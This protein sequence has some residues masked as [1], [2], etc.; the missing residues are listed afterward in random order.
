MVGRRTHTLEPT[1]VH[2]RVQWGNR[3]QPQ[4]LT[5]PNPILPQLVIPVLADTA[6]RV[7]D[8]TGPY[9]SCTLYPLN[10]L[11]ARAVLEHMMNLLSRRSL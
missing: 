8:P 4:L 2:C 6:L 9:P 7:L 11:T 3:I 1:P 5:Q 10:L